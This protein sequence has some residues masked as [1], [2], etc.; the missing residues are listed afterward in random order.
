MD[1]IES[2]Y[3]EI[4]LESGDVVVRDYNLVVDGSGRGIAQFEKMA[5]MSHTRFTDI[6]MAGLFEIT[7]SESMPLIPEIYI[8]GGMGEAFQGKDYMSHIS[9]LNKSVCVINVTTE[10]CTYIKGGKVQADASGKF[11][12]AS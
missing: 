6:K 5:G 7:N 2:A 4:A 3:L 8:L 11:N 9:P 12:S 1:G 10:D